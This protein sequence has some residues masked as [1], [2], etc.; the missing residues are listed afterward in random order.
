MRYRSS[1]CERRYAFS[2]FRRRCSSAESQ[3]VE[4]RVEL[5][6]LRDEIR[7]PLLDGFDRVL[8]R[9]VTGDHD[10]DDFRDTAPARLR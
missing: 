1:S 10:R 8:H 2:D 4:Q 3:H 6:G 7:R 9:A 5:E